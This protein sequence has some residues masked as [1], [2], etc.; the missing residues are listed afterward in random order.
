MA[1]ATQDF[2]KIQSDAEPEE[3]KKSSGTSTFNRVAKYTLVRVVMLFFTVVIG[4]YLTVLIANMGGY[5][6][7]IRIGQITENVGISIGRNPQYKNLTPMEKKE[8]M[9]AIIETEINKLGLDRPFVIRSFGFLENALTMRLG[10]AENMT[11]D[12]G[13]KEVSNILL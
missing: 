7:Q 5:V 2:D 6:D 11:S 10:F 3:E 9:D 1:E 8:L 4:V 13:S 12:S